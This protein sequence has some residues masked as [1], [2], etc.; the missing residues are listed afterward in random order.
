MAGSPSRVAAGICTSSCQRTGSFVPQRPQN[1]R[2]SALDEAKLRTFASP[3]LQLKACAGTLTNVLKAVPCAL[4]QSE[5]WQWL[6]HAGA[7]ATSQPTSP[8]RQLPV[9]MRHSSPASKARS[10]AKP[11]E[12]TR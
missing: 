7:D 8:H 9:V 3:R 4:R 10:E 5:Q 11:S 2:A 12:P 6:I 1:V